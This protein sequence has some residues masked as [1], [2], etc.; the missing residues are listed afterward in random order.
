MAKRTTTRSVK[1][2]GASS[3]DEQTIKAAKATARAESSRTARRTATAE[4]RREETHTR[5]ATPSDPEAI[6]QQKEVMRVRK[7]TG[8]GPVEVVQR[9]ENTPEAQPTTAEARKAADRMFAKADEAGKAEI[10]SETR[11]RSA[12][13]GGR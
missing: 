12:A 3:A 8:S 7:E 10:I 2:K 5:L 4:P 1:V 13:L 6:A 11:L 9:G